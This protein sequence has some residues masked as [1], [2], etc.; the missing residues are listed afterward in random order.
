MTTR[1]SQTPY[2]TLNQDDGI[3]AY[4]ASLKFKGYECNSWSIKPPDQNQ[5]ILVTFTAK[6]YW[7]ETEETF[8]ACLN[9]HGYVIATGY[10]Q[11]PAMADPQDREHHPGCEC[12]KC[13]T[14]QTRRPE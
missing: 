10:Y 14:T 11:E 9:K 2:T 12:N 1:F 13:K 8:T 7:K 3:R 6:A 4:R 5:R